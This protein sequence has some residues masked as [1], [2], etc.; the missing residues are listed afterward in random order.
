M[1]A[2]KFACLI[3][4]QRIESHLQVETPQGSLIQPTHQ[5]RGRHEYAP[6]FASDLE[7]TQAVVYGNKR[8]RE[9]LQFTW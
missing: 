7:G 6:S 8:L 2:Q 1:S 9:Q 4:P 3:G 5:I